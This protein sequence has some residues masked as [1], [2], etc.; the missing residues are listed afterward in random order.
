ML[1][2]LATVT[3][4]AEAIDPRQVSGSDDGLGLV[5]L[6]CASPASARRILDA[7][8]L[9]PDDMVVVVHTDSDDEVPVALADPAVTA[10][11][12]R[13]TVSAPD[14]QSFAQAWQQLTDGRS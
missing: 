9:A 10:G 8:R 5:V 13:F 7:T 11:T 1:H 2:W 6:V 4:G 3:T 14:L 12:V